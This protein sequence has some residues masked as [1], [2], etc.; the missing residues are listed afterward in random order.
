M[1]NSGNLLLASLSAGDADALR[2]HLKPVQLEHE[3]IL[4]EA[5]GTIAD[6]YFPT[7]AIV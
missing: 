3:A 1:Y 6:V 5:G 7:G 4:F 2:P